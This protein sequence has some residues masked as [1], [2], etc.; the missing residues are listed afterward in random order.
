[1]QALA[2]HTTNSQSL[3]DNI[4]TPA[5]EDQN[6]QRMGT[7]CWKTLVEKGVPSGG[8]AGT[9]DRNYQLHLSKQPFVSPPKVFDW[10]LLQTPLYHGAVVIPILLNSVGMSCQSRVSCR[11]HRRS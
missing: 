4:F 3:S 8:C 7:R 10:S 11:T 6:M 2:T 5:A 9:C 1:M